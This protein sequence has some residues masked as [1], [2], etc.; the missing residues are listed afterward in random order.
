MTTI[1]Q[2]GKSWRFVADVGRSVELWLAF[3]PWRSSADAEAHTAAA[4]GKVMPFPQVAVPV[5]DFGLD[6]R[7]WGDFF[8]ALDD[9]GISEESIR[10]GA[11]QMVQDTISDIDSED[12]G[13]SQCEATS[14]DAAN[15]G[16]SSST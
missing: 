3:T 15:S 12:E 7:V 2:R 5:G 1:K 6:A 14:E 4:E 9:L 16:T 13:G 8:V 11:E 10:K